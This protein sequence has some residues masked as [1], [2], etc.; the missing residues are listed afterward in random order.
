MCHQICDKI[1]WNY[2]TAILHTRSIVN[3][4]KIPSSCLW[5]IGLSAD[6]LCHEYRRQLNTQNSNSQ[7]VETRAKRPKCS[8]IFENINVPKLSSKRFQT[9]INQLKTI[10]YS[11][12]FQNVSKCYK[13]IPKYSKTIKK[14][15]NTALTT[16]VR[17]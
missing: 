8:K 10:N 5:V 4:V 1:C 17:V 3:A 6:Y 15:A 7:C 16:V 14:N 2:I 12:M 11:K 13:V 9:N